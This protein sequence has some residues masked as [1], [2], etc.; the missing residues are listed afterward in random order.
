MRKTTNTFSFEVPD[1]WETFPDGC[2]LVAHG[3]QGE[4]V[5]LS[6]WAV[7]FPEGAAHDRFVE[8]MLN[9]ARRSMESAAAN[10][11]L[12]VSKPLE[13]DTDAGGG[14]PC[15]TLIAETRRKDVL[16]A[17]AAIRGSGAVILATFESPYSE[18]YLRRFREFL[19]GFGPPQ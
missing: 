16:F 7:I 4:E 9:A 18:E 2:Q 1:D 11:E 10:P 12:Q 8:G 13:R 14:F 3:P 17:Q 6:S 5:I 15:W 19:A